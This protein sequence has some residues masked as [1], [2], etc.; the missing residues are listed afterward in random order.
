MIRGGIASIMH[1]LY[2]GQYRLDG[3]SRVMI[4]LTYLQIVVVT[5]V[6]DTV[7]DL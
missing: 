7:R 4:L 5:Y 3:A 2:P 6:N 1:H